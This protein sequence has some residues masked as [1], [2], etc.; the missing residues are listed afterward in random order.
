MNGRTWTPA[1][2]ATVRRMAGRVADAEIARETGHCERT[3]RDRRNA[4]GL[5][6]Y[7]HRP[8]WTRRDYLLAGA[9]GLMENAAL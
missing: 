2:T 5:P 4:M 1:D 8:K 7:A 3:I 9:A 6:A